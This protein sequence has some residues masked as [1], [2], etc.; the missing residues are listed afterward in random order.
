[1]VTSFAYYPSWTKAPED[2]GHAFRTDT[3]KGVSV[4]RCWHYVPRKANTVKRIIHKGTFVACSFLRQ[5]T[6]PAPG[7][8]RCHVT[9]FAAGCCVLVAQ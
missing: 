8:L 9:A 5:L 4:H 7:C 6:L 2:K 3:M 1:M